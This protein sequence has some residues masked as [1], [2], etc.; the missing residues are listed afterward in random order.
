M[1]PQDTRH[2]RLRPRLAMLAIA[3][4][5]LAPAAAWAAS[6]F[7]D[8]PKGHLFHDDIA[9]MAETGV[10][11]GCNPPAN[12]RYCPDDNVTRGEM[13]AFIHRLESEG[14]F[15]TASGPFVPVATFQLQPGKGWSPDYRS[16]ITGMSVKGQ[17]HKYTVEFDG[18]S[19]STTSDRAVCTPTGSGAHVVSV[20][21]SGGDLLVHVF[22]E[23][24]DPAAGVTVHCAIYDS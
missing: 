6:S 24:G 9:W 23:D 17:S 7:K 2:S 11:K 4:V 13:A 15:L 3:L 21:S 18:F 10:T 22:N 8:V 5:A 20:S 1:H 12:D 19:F 14:V 16:P